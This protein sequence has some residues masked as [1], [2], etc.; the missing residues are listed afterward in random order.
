[1]GRPTIKKTGPMTGAE[2]EARRRKRKG[3]S[4]N[5]RRRKLY[6]GK[7]LSAVAAARREASRNAPPLP[8]GAELRI[9]DCRKVLNNLENDSVALILTDP[10]YAADAL[11][12]YQRP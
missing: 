7:K 8:D 12:L 1:M 10:P 9:G 2:R 11:P 5:R 3:K 4:I 6:K